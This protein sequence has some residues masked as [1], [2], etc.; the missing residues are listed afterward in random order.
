MTCCLYNA[1]VDPLNHKHVKMVPREFLNATDIET[2]EIP[3]NIS[4]ISTYAFSGCRNLRS[5]KLPKDL[6][7]I[8]ESFSHCDNLTDVY[9][10]GTCE[11][12]RKIRIYAA[13]R[14]N[15]NI[16]CTDGD[17]QGDI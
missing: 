4:I 17:M 15:I 9:Y 10:D 8:S 11:D 6:I 13:S 12:F 1:G 7:S 5:I 16:H 3:E 2:F 14:F